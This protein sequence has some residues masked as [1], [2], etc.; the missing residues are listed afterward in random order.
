MALLSRPAVSPV[1]RTL[2]AVG[3]ALFCGA[4]HAQHVRAGGD[5]LTLGL[6]LGPIDNE[7]ALLGASVGTQVGRVR[8]EIRASTLVLQEVRVGRYGGAVNDSAREV[9]VLVGLAQTVAASWQVSALAGVSF[10]RTVRHHVSSPFTW[11]AEGDPCLPFDVT[12][13]TSAVQLGLPV[14][15]S[16]RGP[17]VGAV[18]V[19]VG[20]FAN[21]GARDVTYAGTSFSLF[22]SPLRRARPD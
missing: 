11:C 22:V 2:F 20:V 10:V 16:A 18:D 13:E 4:A 6:S 5:P 19:G 1:T 14:D 7:G 21:V 17:L 8:G 12:R 9:A 15:V 3:V